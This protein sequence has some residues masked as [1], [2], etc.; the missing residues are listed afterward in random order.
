MKNLAMRWLEG[1]SAATGHP[2]TDESGLVRIEA[3]MASRRFE[4]LLIEPNDEEFGNIT[5][6]IGGDSRDVF[7][8]FTNKPAHY[9]VPHSGL[10][11]DRDDEALMT[12]SLSLAEALVPEGFELHWEDQGDRVSLQIVHRDELAAGGT[13][14]LVGHDAIFDR[15]ETMPRYQRRGLGRFVMSALTNWAIDHGADLGILAA[16]ADGQALY[17]TL[18]WHTECAMLMFRGTI[19]AVVGPVDASTPVDASL[20]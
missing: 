13:L 17:A 15:I 1:W 8:V 4:Y 9:L 10:V 16:S 2:W 6:L 12:L 19:D 7:T 5:A 3:L 11:V 18:G 14:A 20:G